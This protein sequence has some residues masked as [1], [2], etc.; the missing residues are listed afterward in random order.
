MAPKAPD[1]RPVEPSAEKTIP[2]AKDLTAQTPVEPAP[3]TLKSPAAAPEP[4]AKTK[5]VKRSTPQAPKIS[6][7]PKV[8][9]PLAEKTE[10]AVAAEE[11]RIPP[12]WELSEKAQKKLKGLE[13]NI[14]VYHEQPVERFVIIDMRR[15][16]EGDPLDRPGLTLERITRDGVVIHYGKGRVKL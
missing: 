15:Y 7:E 3:R 1:P 9:K 12:I 2:A 16:R 5:T 10:E 14:H 6:A 11:P 13:I 4:A 8:V